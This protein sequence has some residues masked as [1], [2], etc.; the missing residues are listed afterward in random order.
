M[1]LNGPQSGSQTFIKQIIHALVLAGRL[2][3]DTVYWL[4]NV[5]DAVE[6]MRI[7]G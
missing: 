4:S 3:P 6:E 5:Y 1:R 2:I 7:F